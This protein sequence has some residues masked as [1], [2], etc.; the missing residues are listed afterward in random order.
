MGRLTHPSS[1]SVESFLSFFFLA[2]F[3]FDFLTTHRV[4]VTRIA[5]RNAPA[6]G[7][8]QDDLT[9]SCAGRPLDRIIPFP[10]PHPPP[11]HT[12]HSHTHISNLFPTRP[13]S[14]AEHSPYTQ[15]PPIISFWSVDYPVGP[16]KS[17]YKPLPT[18]CS[19]PLLP[20]SLYGAKSYETYPL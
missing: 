11:T 15:L 3:S 16:K 4:P 2:P 20:L 5:D 7:I 6:P 13:T 19:I 9:P 8:G 10:H 18:H 17:K 1:I 14:E 12:Y